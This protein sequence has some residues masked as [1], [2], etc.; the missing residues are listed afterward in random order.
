MKSY[1][2]LSALVGIPFLVMATK[3]QVLDTSERSKRADCRIVSVASGDGCA[4]LATKCGITPAQFTSFN[5]G[6]DCSKLKV[7]QWVCCSSGTLP[8]KRPVQNPDGSCFS[9]DIVDG[10]DC[11]QFSVK[12]DVTLTEIDTW[13]K[14][15]WRWS[16]CS[17]LQPGMK[18]CMSTGTPPLP[19]QN[20]SIPCGLESV[21]NKECPLRACCGKW[22]FCG[23]TDDFC[24]T[25]TGAP[26]TGCQ[27]NCQKISDFDNVGLSSSN[28]GRN[29]IG[30][31]SNWSAHRSCNGVPN[32]V[33][34]AVRPSDLDPNSFTHIVYSFASVSRGDFKLTETQ[35]DDKQLIAELQALKKTNPNLK[36]MW[37][38]GGWAFN[39][40]PTQDI[41]SL[42]VRTPASRTTFVN[43]VISQLTSY[44]FDGL[45]ID[46]EY[47]GSERGGIEADGQNFLALMKEL[48]AATSA[49]RMEVSFTA[50]ASYWYLQQFPILQM[51]DYTNWINLMTYD[52]HGSWDIKFGLGVLPHTAITEVNAAVNMLLKAG[53]KIGKINLGIGFYGRSFTLTDPSCHVA[54]CAFSGP[55]IMGPCTGGEGFLSYAEI[56]YLIQTKGLTPTYNA[57]SKTMTLVYDNQ[58]IGYED[59]TTLATKLKYVLDRT[60]PGVLIWAVDLDKSNQLLSA[61]VGHSLIPVKSTTDCPADGIWKTTPAGQTASV[62][63]GS[64]SSPH[65]S[66]KCVGPN[67]AD[68]GQSFCAA[69]QM[70]LAAFGHCGL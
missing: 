65:R 13:N 24:E 34:P 47:P 11:S 62:P 61:V 16:G 63:C 52:I 17:G 15:T 41:F 68:E 44:G 9:V 43:N 57:T 35:S 46:W 39:D 54:G 32:G 42:M 18:I 3:K 45:D 38:V 23:L 7:D 36:T 59:P 37:A 40:P 20:S 50:P 60:M 66:R 67:W 31:Y 56:D 64:G 6:L 25:S 14:K 51:Q 27:S 70:M 48:Y 2:L 26:G 33:L 1:T 4:S 69:S 8:S 55:G 5:P 53:V 22:G 29:I 10:S 58:W 12:Y 21:G 30:Y 28:P 49:K 19:V